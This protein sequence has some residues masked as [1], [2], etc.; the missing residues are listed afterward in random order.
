[1]TA[2]RRSKL[3]SVWDRRVA[4]WQGTVEASPGFALVRERIMQ[5]A[6]PQPTDRCVD[7]GAGTGLLTLPLAE[8][9]GEAVAADIS[10][11]MLS[12]LAAAARRRGQRVRTHTSAMED[13]HFPR[14]SFELVVSNYAM[15][16][17][18]DR[19]KAA[20][21]RKILGWLVPGGRVVIGD[22]MIGRSMDDHHRRVLRQK[23]VVLLRRGPAGWWRLL[24]NVIRVGTGKGRLRPAAPQWWTAALTEAGFRDVRYEHVLSEAG[25]VTG[26]AR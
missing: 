23:A 17:L 13:L 15:H 18:T 16:Y 22:M 9:A 10:G 25:I 26:V 19:D 12:T 24:K 3:G 5:L 11:G 20:M 14:G 6:A 1:M 21:L 8:R 4:Q 7:L 2:W